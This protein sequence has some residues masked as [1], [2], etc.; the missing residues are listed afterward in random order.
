MLQYE[1]GD[2]N[3]LCLTAFGLH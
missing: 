1:T 2:L 3:F